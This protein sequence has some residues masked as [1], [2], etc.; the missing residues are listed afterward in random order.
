MNVYKIYEKHRKLY[1]VL[2]TMR[3]RCN[4]NNC[5]KFS[6]Y[7][8][9]GI[10]VC[11]EWNSNPQSFINWALKNGYKDGLSIDRI[12]NN[13]NYEPSN[14]RWTTRNIQQR[15]T[16]KLYSTNM[17]GFRGIAKHYKKYKAQI[18][19]NGEKH[20]IGLYN[21]AEEAGYAYDKYVIDNNLEHTTNGLYAKDNA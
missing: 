6:S 11:E 7:G 13:G 9:R 18:R 1:S 10:R 21:T 16:R 8:E 20:Y 12:D 4:N 19:V 14:C 2:I 3:Q 5:K 15:N 17:Q